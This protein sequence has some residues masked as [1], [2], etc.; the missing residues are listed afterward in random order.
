MVAAQVCSPLSSVTQQC[1]KNDQM[2]EMANV[3]EH[4]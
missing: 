4:V 2:A 3:R 1:L